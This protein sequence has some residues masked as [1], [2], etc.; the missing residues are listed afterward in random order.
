MSLDCLEVELDSDLLGT[1]ATVCTCN[2]RP[3]T[4]SGELL[5]TCRDDS[6]DSFMI[7]GFPALSMISVI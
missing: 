6:V 1:V 3:G 2:A 5:E 4:T 7:A